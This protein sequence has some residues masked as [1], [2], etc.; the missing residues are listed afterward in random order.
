MNGVELK[1][2]T[3]WR[4]MLKRCYCSAYIKK[5]PTYIDCTVCDEWLDFREFKKWHDTNYFDEAVLDKDISV[6]GNKIYSP[7]YCSYVPLDINAIVLDGEGRRGLFKKGVKLEKRNGTFTAQLNKKNKSF[8][9]GTFKTEDEAHNAYIIEKKKYMKEIA[10]KYF[11]S[12]LIIER[13]YLSLI[14]WNI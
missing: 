8:H 10:E 5:F 11:N 13:V 12:N 7:E 2:Y 3:N 4:G 14:N 6:Q 1:S 9:I